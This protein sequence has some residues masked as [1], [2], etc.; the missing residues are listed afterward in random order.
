M[1]VTGFVRKL[2][3]LG[4][5]TLPMDIR[6]SLDIAVGDPMEI[7]VDGESILLR[8]YEPNC[9]FCNGTDRILTF[10]EQNICSSCVKALCAG[11]DTSTSDCLRHNESKHNCIL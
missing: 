6:K 3:R 5:L 10:Q 8:K 7:L 11:F 1:K 4:R 9:V 2:D